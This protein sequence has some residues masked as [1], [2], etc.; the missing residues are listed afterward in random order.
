M[1]ALAAAAI[2]VCF[3]VLDYFGDKLRTPESIAGF[4]FLAISAGTGYTLYR[5]QRPCGWLIAMVS[6]LFCTET[7]LAYI[8]GG[9]NAPSVVFY[10]PMVAAV[11]V[12]LGGRATIV[13]ATMCVIAMATF[14][15]AFRSGTELCRRYRL[16][17]PRGDAD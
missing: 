13:F 4:V 16:R 12:V 2:L 7:T 10:L 14:A 1:H 17:R 8:H 9:L 5:P 3:V 11:A 6:M 15:W